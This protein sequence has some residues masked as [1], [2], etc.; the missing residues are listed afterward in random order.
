M[1]WFSTAG[2]PERPLA[3]AQ[4]EVVLKAAH[5]YRLIARVLY[6]S[7][8]VYVLR[9]MTHAEYDRVDWPTQCGC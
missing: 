8:K 3:F 5:R 6:R 4:F 7:H 2:K 9:V 1:F